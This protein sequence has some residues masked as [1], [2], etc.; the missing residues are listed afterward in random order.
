LRYGLAQ[1]LV[2]VGLKM[3]FLNAAWNGHF[4][5]LISLGVILGILGVAI[6]LSV[7]LPAPPSPS[8]SSAEV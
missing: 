2:F 8:N 6:A 1:I 7:I 5:P 3:S 4:P